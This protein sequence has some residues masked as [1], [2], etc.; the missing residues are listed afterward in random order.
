MTG[1][2]PDSKDDRTQHGPPGLPRWV[3]LLA[4]GVIVAVVVLVL[5]MLLIGGEHG[6]GRHGG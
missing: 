2:A 4:I 1:S 6:P 5:V 3:K